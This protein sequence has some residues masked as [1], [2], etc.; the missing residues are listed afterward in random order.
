MTEPITIDSYNPTSTA[1]EG[2]KSGMLGRAL[3][4]LKSEREVFHFRL[5]MAQLMTAPLPVHVGSRLR[6]KALAMAGF[7]IGSRTVFWGMPRIVGHKNLYQNLEIGQDC[8]LQI[9]CYLDLGGRITIDDRAGIGY[10]VMLMTTTHKI[11]SPERRVGAVQTAAVHIGK[12]VWIGAR[13]IIMPG[14]TIHDGSVVGAG[15]LVTKDV[16]PNTIVG[17]VPAKILRTIEDPK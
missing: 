10:E 12:G 17:G 5:W 8:W 14:V 3:R 9:G 4:Y 13:A 6:A 1:S 16:P 2:I 15:A 11:G 7:K